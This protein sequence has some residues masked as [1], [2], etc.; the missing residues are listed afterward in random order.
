[1]DVLPRLTAEKSIGPALGQYAARPADLGT[2]LE[3]MA[4]LRINNNP[5]SLVT[6]HQRKAG[7]LPSPCPP[8]TNVCW[9]L[10]NT[11]AAYDFDCCD[12]HQPCQHDPGGSP[13]CQPYESE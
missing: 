11:Y 6:V 2:G 13:F 12:P 9:G 7:L 10:D 4:V 8:G 3:P 5:E 1:M